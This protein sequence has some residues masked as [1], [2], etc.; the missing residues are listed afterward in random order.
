MFGK[1]ASQ[2]RSN[3]SGTRR[4]V[5][6]DCGS[7]RSAMEA[8]RP[9]GVSCVRRLLL[10][11][12]G[13]RELTGVFPTT[14]CVCVC[15]YA[16][17]H[18]WWSACVRGRAWDAANAVNWDLKQFK[19]GRI[20]YGCEVISLEHSFF[21]NNFFYFFLVNEPLVLFSFKVQ[22]SFRKI[23]CLKKIQE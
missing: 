7:L 16:N 19:L 2:N 17:M 8:K 13:G 21:K 22:Q 9:R 4:S 5:S 12:K 15:M 10:I 6:A 14:L 3:N 18:V 23:R 1:L 11:V 20:L